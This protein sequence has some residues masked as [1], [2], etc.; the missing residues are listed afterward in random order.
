[1]AKIGFFLS[2]Q[3]Q[4]AK[5]P[6]PSALGVWKVK[7]DAYDD[8]LNKPLVQE[9]NGYAYKA[10]RLNADDFEKVKRLV[11]SELRSGELGPVCFESPEQFRIEL[12]QAA[13][14]QQQRAAQRAARKAK[15][16]KR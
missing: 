7:D 14:L 10:E 8:V 6:R 1:M 4:Y 3:F 15:R 5:D 16:K 9:G 13:L 11:L 2:G 12:E